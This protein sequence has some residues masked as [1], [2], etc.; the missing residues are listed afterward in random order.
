MTVLNTAS[1]GIF[2]L[3]I[4]LFRAVHAYGPMTREDL[5]SLCAAGPN[6]D[7]VRLG[8]TL[9][10]WADL[11]L[12]EESDGTYAVA[13]DARPGTGL[14][15]DVDDATT[16]LPSLVR[17]VAFRD[18]NNERFWDNAG[19]LGADLT[20]SL[21]WLLAQDIYDTDVSDHDALWEL[22]SKQ[23][24]DPNRWLVRNNVRYQGLLAWGSYLGFL[25]C[26]DTPVVDPTAALRQDL[27]L[28][29]GQNRELTAAAFMERTAAVLPV[30]DSGRYRQELE[31]ALD[32]ASWRRPAREDQLST[33]LSRAI[34]RLEALGLL[35]LENRSDAG[36]ARVL[37]RQQGADWGRFTH[38]RLSKEAYR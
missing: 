3:L 4:V 7:T 17:S 9:R 24:K 1:D 27:P 21:A 2:N 37:T 15:T 25:W 38:I 26:T 10:R 11:G 14:P 18:A 5:I 22:E 33:A 12:F 28:I 8:Q 23:I 35:I 36:D 16:L 29:F 30:L 34:R 13:S 32:P 6:C 19:S 20:R 31:A